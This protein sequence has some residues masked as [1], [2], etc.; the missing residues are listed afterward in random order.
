MGNTALKKSAAETSLIEAYEKTHTELPG[1]GAPW[2]VELRKESAAQ[3]AGTGLPNKRVEEWKYTD[4]KSI[5]SELPPVAMAPHKNKELTLTDDI[6]A[7]FLQTDRHT[8]VFVNGF[9]VPELSNLGGLQS[10][11][12]MMSLEEAIFRAPDWVADNL[13]KISDDSEDAILALN[14]SLMSGG[15]A[16]R[17]EKDTKVE[18]PIE[19]VFVS[20]GTAPSSVMA[21]ALIV[22]EEGAEVSLF[23]THISSD[24]PSH[25]NLVTEISIADKAKLSLAKVQFEKA[26]SAHLSTRFI[27]MGEKADLSDFTLNL[28]ADMA[29]N[30]THLSFEGEHSEAHLSGAYILGGSRHSDTTIF[31]DHKVPSCLSKEMF[32]GV[33]DETSTGVFQGKI[34]V[35][36]GAQHTDGQMMTQ[37]LLLSED[38]HFYTKPELEIYADDV[39]C[40]HGATSGQID[41][42]LMFYL[43]SR[44]IP[45]KQARAMIIQAFV[46]EAL[47][48]VR[49]EDVQ[50]ILAG[51]V[52]ERL[53]RM[54][55]TE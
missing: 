32:K 18:K 40:A 50:G 30:Q 33:L 44:G 10:E 39:Q 37:A 16:L 36:N 2:L 51:L 49:D 13:S 47:E 21:R 54:Q 19:F 24:K 29:R 53:S 28:G 5:L 4:L 9:F 41:D 45:P 25:L 1:S 23:E 43:L 34:I 11:V 6:S 20:E 55:D 14:T 3:F 38:A 17:V 12:D 52:E 15:Y 35:H 8:A 48:N 22:I 46:S 27:R 31:I 42:D 26:N 7:G